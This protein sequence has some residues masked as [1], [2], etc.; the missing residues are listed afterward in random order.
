MIRCVNIKYKHALQV[1]LV[2]KQVYTI[3][4]VSDNSIVDRKWTDVWWENDRNILIF[5]SSFHLIV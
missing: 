2:F 5:L 1:Y 3:Q 4:L